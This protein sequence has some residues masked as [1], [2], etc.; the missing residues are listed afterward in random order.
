MLALLSL[1]L[2]GRDVYDILFLR[3]VSGEMEE[4]VQPITW[5]EA[6]QWAVSPTIIPV[7][8]GAIVSTLIE[9]FP[10]FDALAPRW[11]RVVFFLIS[12]LVP[13]AGAALGILTLGWTNA[14]ESTWWNA[15]QAGVLAFAAGTV[16]HARKLAA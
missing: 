1:C 12:L 5:A 4:T 10:S 3:Y 6:L 8:T 7:V 9:Y 2:T 14:W 13:L 15:I 11:K 16:V